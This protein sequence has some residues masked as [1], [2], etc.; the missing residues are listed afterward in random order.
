MRHI[1]TLAI[2]LFAFTAQT[3]WSAPVLD[4]EHKA[5]SVFSTKQ[6]NEK[7]CY[8]TSSPI[9]K[10]GNYTRRGEP[11]ALVTYRGDGVSEVS[12][13]SGYP[14]KN[15]SSVA[16][17]VDKKKDFSLFTTNETPKI[18][19]ARD[20]SGDKAIITAM[21]AGVRMSAKGF[22]SQRNLFLR[23]LLSLRL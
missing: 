4:S 11:Y 13:S 1:I 2:F 16:L 18:S 17:S 8:I 23:Y 12:I 14:Y 7:I 5:W 3:A 21:K 19:W 20:S 10:T 22:F 9:S 6:G 15:K